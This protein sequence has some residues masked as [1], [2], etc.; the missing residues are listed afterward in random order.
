[1]RGALAGLVVPVVVGAFTMYSGTTSTPNEVAV[2]L[3]LVALI[4]MT[5][6]WIA[7]PLAGGRQRRLLVAALGYAIALIVANGCLSLIQAAADA[8]VAN[9]PDPLALATS[10]AGRAVVA[11]AGTAYLIVPA[12]VVGLAWSAVAR[13]LDPARPTRIA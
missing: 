13:V 7:G 5:A 3:A 8:L 1:V 4:G 9:G 10:V 2:G 12:V 6:G 11:A